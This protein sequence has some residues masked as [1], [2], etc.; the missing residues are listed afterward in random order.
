MRVHQSILIILLIFPCIYSI[1]AQKGSHHYQIDATGPDKTVY[2]DHLAL[3]GT[4]FLEERIAFNNYYMLKDG[5]PY[6]PITGEFHYSRYPNKYWEESIRKMKAGGINTI[7]TYVFWIMH[8]EIEG[9]FVWTGDYNLRKFIELCKLNDIDVIVRIGPFCH[10]EIR[11]GGLPEWLLGKPLTIRSNDPLYLSY[12]ERLYNQIGLQLEGLLFKDGGPVIGIQLENE[13]QHSAAPWGLTYPGEPYDWTTAEQD[14]AVT[15]A[16]VG[17]SEEENPYHELG[18]EHMRILKSLAIKAGLEVPVYTATGWGNAAIIENGT[19]PVT[20]AYPYPTWADLS[21]SPLYLYRDLQKSPDYAPVS[22]EPDDYPYMA[23][24][25]GGG[26]M[27]RYNRR[28]TVPPQCLDALINRFLG[29]GANGIGY[30]MYHGGSTP[31]GELNYF[32]DEAYGYPKISYDFQAPLGEFGQV[33][34]SFNRLKILHYFIES[35]GAQMAPMGV[36][37]AEKPVT[38]PDNLKDLRYSVRKTGDTGFIFMHNYQDHLQTQD[39]QNIRFTIKTSHGN[40]LVP[41][42]GEFDLLSE[43]NFIIPFNLDLNGL[44]LNYAIAQ[45]LIRF[46]NNNIQYLI[47][48]TPEGIRPEFSIQKK[49]GFIV[50]GTS[51]TID[52]NEKRWLINSEADIPAEFTIGKSDGSL[53]KVL[54]IS[55]ELAEKSWLIEDKGNSAIAFSDAAIIKDN[56]GLKLLQVDES[57]IQVRI[58]PEADYKIRSQEELTINEDKLFTS[59]ALELIKFNETIEKREITSGK[60]AVKLPV[61]IPNHINEIILDIDYTGDVGMGFLN[62]KLVADDF[63]RGANWQIGLRKFMGLQEREEM[64][65]YFRPMQAGAEYLE[66][67]SDDNIPDFGENKSYLEI[68]KVKF[69]AIYQALIEIIM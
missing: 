25:I 41:E 52:E 10:G 69:I 26:I 33:R 57:H 34:P 9:K 17:I 14:R 18:Q 8:E 3:G 28:P 45:P 48:F 51:C 16:G 55:K 64:V 22:Y 29:S 42:S 61:K 60:L 2:S 59:I 68:N 43:Q 58:Y 6:I 56:K 7:A 20:S 49:S 67:F 44:N 37:N 27:V 40:I 50:N 31:R 1:N 15:Q 19:I 38:E 13:Y 12:V 11:N 62:G 5:K 47:F 32:T 66:D 39:I 53:L 65:L 35:F 4:N 30:Y 23:A 63:Y 36:V 46:T 54:V 21:L 24:E